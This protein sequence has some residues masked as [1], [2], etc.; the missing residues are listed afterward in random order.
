M[1][2]NMKKLLEIISASRRLQYINLS[3]N[4]LCDSKFTDKEQLE[5]CGLLGQAIKRNK[6]LLHF[7]LT[8]T[9]LTTLIIKEMGSIIRR[10]A[11][12]LCVHLSDNPG[13]NDENCDY[14]PKRIKC[15][16]RED[17]E[18]FNRIQNLVI[19]YFEEIPQSH[20]EGIVRKMNNMTVFKKNLTE[21]TNKLIFNRFIGFKEQQPGSGQWYESSQTA[22]ANKKHF[23]N[24]CWICE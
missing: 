4:N 20:R 2:K 16:P 1:P 14:L 18:R 21:P 13:L 9:G 24:D 19:R 7:D 3:W 15:R 11:S 10:A 8:S 22:V 6:Q 5:I 23:K 12:V 17:I